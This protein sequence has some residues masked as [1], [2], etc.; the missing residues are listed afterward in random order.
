MQ[1]V[2]NMD[3]LQAEAASSFSGVDAVFCAL[4]TT[5]AVSERI[6]KK[7]IEVWCASSVCCHPATPL[8]LLLM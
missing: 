7:A 3:A 8:L 6:G 2:V 1:V 5:R 4:G